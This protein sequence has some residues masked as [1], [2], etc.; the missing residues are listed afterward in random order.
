MFLIYFPQLVS[1]PFVRYEDQRD[2]LFSFHKFNLDSIVR[3]FERFL[4]GCFKKL[5]IA[6]RIAVVTGNIF[7]DWNRFTGFYIIFGVCCFAFQLYADFSGCMDIMLGVSEMFQ[8]TLPEN[9]K[10]PFFSTS[11]AEFWRRWHITLGTW[12]KDYVLYPLLKTKPFARMGKA[13]KDRWGKKIGR[14][15]P[16]FAGMIIIWFLIGLWHGGS[17]KFMFCSGIIPCIY[18]L[19]GRI[20]S[21]YLNRL[22]HILGIKTDCFSY[23]LFLRIRTTILVMSTWLIMASGSLRVSLQKFRQIIPLN[24]PY[25]FFGKNMY[26]TGLDG[27][28]FLLLWI[29]LLIVL[30][31]D[32]MEE[33]GI[34]VRK[35]L[36]GQ[37]TLFRWGVL[38]ALMFAVIVFGKYGPGYNAADFIYGGM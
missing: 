7:F 38:Y 36:S 17:A 19:G 10:R 5:V 32:T 8:I 14:E 18:L 27:K 6:D 24:N 4:W 1:G 16:T 22:T 26:S 13:A 29:C 12:A 37:N 3:G 9:F 35:S 21:P 33:H 11:Y 30:V 25:I 2:Q 34:D 15:I 28:D 23:R 20:L 31:V